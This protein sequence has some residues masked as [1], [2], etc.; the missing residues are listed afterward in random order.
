M[1]VPKQLS[2]RL[3]SAKE[4]DVSCIRKGMSVIVTT[5]DEGL[6]DGLDLMRSGRW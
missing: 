2:G 1:A 4:R 5:G 3:M 6:M